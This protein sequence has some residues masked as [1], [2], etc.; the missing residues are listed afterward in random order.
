[1]RILVVGGGGREHAIIRTFRREQAGL[2]I[3]CA[4]GS[5]GI[6][7]LASNLQIPVDDLDG[8]VDA[9]NRHRIELAVVGPELPLALG[10]ADRLRAQGHPVLGPGAA[11]ARIESSKAFAK[12][13][14]RAAGVPTAEWA[15]FRDLG[16]ALAHVD[17]HAEPLVVKAS[18]LAAGKGAMVC[19][20][21]AEAREAVTR[22]LGEH[23]FGEAGD[24]IVIESFLPGEELSVFAVTNGREMSLLPAAQDY[25]RIGEGDTGPNTGGM[26]ACSPVSF[27]TPEL[28]TRVERDILRP[29]LAELEARNARFRGILYAGLMIAPDGSPSVIEF[30]CRLGDPEAQTVLPTLTGDFLLACQAAASGGRIPELTATGRFAITTVLA[31]RGYPDAPTRGDHITLPSDQSRDAIFFHAG[32]TRDPKGGFMTAGGRV[33][34]C[35]GLGDTF[36]MARANSLRLAEGT[37]FEGKQFRHDIGWREAERQGIG[38]GTPAGT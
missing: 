18:G 8:L 25:K 15:V 20:T 12:D 27:A 33:A 13:V 28:M 6:A 10:L 4:P 1:M 23:A 22:M 5:P 2:D 30:N 3:Y 14:M 21:R 37:Q 38:Q 7:S 24:E 34:A 16:E 36:E 26:G 17:D 31:T 32:T 19:A 9:A 11:A 35:T 29:T